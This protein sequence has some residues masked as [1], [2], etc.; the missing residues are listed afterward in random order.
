VVGFAISEGMTAVSG[1]RVAR[2]GLFELD[3]ESG[4]LRRQGIRIHL[5]PKSFLVLRA[6]LSQSGEVVSRA[7]LK[8]RLW[9]EDTFVEFEASLNVAVRRLRIALGEDA[10]IPRYIET[11]P[12]QGYRFIA[13]PE[14]IVTG[15]KAETCGSE[16]D[17]DAVPE[18]NS[19]DGQIASQR[20]SV[21]TRSR[22]LLWL[23]SGLFIVVAAS[24]LGVVLRRAN[25][26]HLELLGKRPMI[27]AE[28]E[29][30]TSDPLLDGAL[31][32]A[33]Q[34]DLAN[35]GRLT[36]LGPERIQDTLR[37]MR[38][39][40]DS[41]VDTALAEE[42]AVRDGGIGGVI[43]GSVSKIGSTYLLVAELT[44]SS[45]GSILRS[46]NES[47]SEQKE[48]VGAVHRLSNRIRLEVGEIL[49]QNQGADHPL[50][51]VTTPSIKSLQLYSQANR[52][53]VMN[54]ATSKAAIDLLQQAID[55]DPNFASAHIVL[56]DAL[57]NF[58]RDSEAQAHAVRA[59]E[60]SINVSDRERLFILGSYYSRFAA[61]TNAHESAIQAF[62]ELVRRYPGDYWSLR[63]LWLLYWASGRLDDSIRTVQ[64]ISDTRPND[65]ES[66][67]LA[68]HFLHVYGHLPEAQRYGERAL[69]ALQQG[70]YNLR[71]DEDSL[72]T[73]RFATHIGFEV[74]WSLI[75]DGRLSEA[76]A[77]A[78]RQGASLRLRSADEQHQVAIEETKFNLQIGRLR[79]ADAWADRISDE[80]P[81]LIAKMWIAVQRDDDN[82]YYALRKA[83]AT[84]NVWRVVPIALMARSGMLAEAERNFNS[85][86][87][88]ARIDPNYG[89]VS[90]RLYIALMEGEIASAQNRRSLALA[91]LRSAAGGFGCDSCYF[92]V[93]MFATEAYARE[94]DRNGQ[95]N[96]AILAL[97]RYR[98]QPVVNL[99]ED[100]YA[101]PLTLRL[102]L[103]QLYRKVG[104]NGDAA[105]VEAELR[106]TLAFAD[107][108]HVVIKCLSRQRPGQ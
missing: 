62:E 13:Q 59:R 98:S 9:P 49:P 4:V 106:R 100:D 22:A 66:A 27:I 33:L 15:G 75:W 5:Q 97:E 2:F 69:S 80:R 56:A 95:T 47:A 82:L 101:S 8:S 6:L 28:F 85:Y 3:L 17:E 31:A 14:I 42:I 81:R 57:K 32:S 73:D 38:R 91:R 89:P 64:T 34:F 103:A 60:L 25:T 7:Q 104:R 12:R 24:A 71:G 44:D 29:N 93:P 36:V 21:L 102:R 90:T 65:F 84:D 86:R 74:V 11:I 50:E 83:T 26:R 41:R 45:T 72:S 70:G 68:Y 51:R 19:I 63:N 108:D 105:L 52:L 30:H 87:R 76:I 61:E 55:V 35:S 79:M 94:L 1:R 16:A 88:Q 10:E 96:E 18:P 37:L 40:L 48:I 46:W 99:D 92:P 58:R 78:E 20:H 77:E 43:G 39:P 107:S 53:L 54:D 67:H 23:A